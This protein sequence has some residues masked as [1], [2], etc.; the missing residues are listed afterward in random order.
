MS[1]YNSRHVQD[2]QDIGSTKCQAAAGPAQAQGRTGPGQA[3]EAV[4]SKVDGS[5]QNAGAD[6]RRP[7]NL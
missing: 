3:R 7:Y 1:K 2:I 4:G 5:A 6:I